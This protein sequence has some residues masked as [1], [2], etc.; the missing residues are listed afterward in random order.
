MAG[1]DINL[2]NAWKATTGKPDVLVAII[3]GGIDYTHE[4]LAANIYKNPAELNGKDGVDDDGNGYPDDI[5]GWNFCTNEPKIYPHS[6]GT[7]WPAL[8][9]LSTTTASA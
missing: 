6:H 9:R 4:D 1:A 5:Y 2:F 7:P 8:W 3:D